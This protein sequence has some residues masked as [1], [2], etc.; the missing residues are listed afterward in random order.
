MLNLQTIAESLNTFCKG[1]AWII[2]TA[3]EA[4]EKVVGD[5]SASQSNDFSKIQARFNI[6]L[7]LTSRNVEEVIQKRLLKKKSEVE[8]ELKL[9][10][11]Q[12]SSNFGTL[13]N[14]ADGSVSL[15]SFRDESH[16][17]E[18][19]PFIP[20]QFTLFRESIKGLSDHNAF[21]GRHASV[22]ERSLL[23]VFRDVSIAISSKKVGAIAPFDMMYSGISS[24]L[25]TFIQS[26]IQVAE[27]NLNN[28]FAVRVLKALFLVKYYDQFKP[29]LHNITILMLERFDV[30]LPQLKEKIKEALNILEQ[31]TYIQRN[32]DMYEFL[33]KEEKDIETE[34]KNTEIDNSDLTDAIHELIFKDIIQSP[35][36][37]Y[38]TLNIDY[39]YATKVDGETKGYP[40]ELG[41]NIITP[42]N[43]AGAGNEATIAESMSSDDLYILLKQT[44]IL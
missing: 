30:N 20:Y 29:T 6:R 19:Y 34:I 26:S 4:L 1:Q 2:V 31:E 21:E 44:K 22:G 11:D 27:S 9:I 43:N 3:Q 13:F 36:I 23:G 10:Y 24:V 17:I 25:K 7:P 15:N 37:R 18:S 42:L 39:K 14:F 8:N 33:T 38:S 35:K 40:S 28:E 41:I 32:G 12:E 16:F 5:I